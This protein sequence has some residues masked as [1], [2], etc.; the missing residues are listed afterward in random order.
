MR[1]CLLLEGSYPYITGGV[2]S[3]VQDMIVGLPEIEFALFTIS[4]AHDQTL[5]YKLPP[6][7]V[8]HVDLVI[9]DTGVSTARPRG[10]KKVMELMTAAHADFFARKKIDIVE[11]IERMPEGYFAHADVLAGSTGWNLLEKANHDHNPM[12]AFSDYFWSWKSSHNMLFA[13]LGTRPPAADIY[14]AI[15]TGYAGLAAVAAKIRRKKPFLLTEHGLYHKEREIE[16]R[17]ATFVRGYQR[18]MWI[19]IYN[20]LSRL[21]YQY[22]DVSTSLFEYNRRMQIELGAQEHKTE[23]IP[24]GIDVE[25][26]TVAREKRPG[27]HVGLVG[28]VVPIKDIKTFITMA[29]IVHSR[30]PEA[31]FYC[32][33]PTDEDPAYHEDCL[34]LVDS[35]RLGEVFE[36]TGRKNVLDYYAFLD[37]MLLTSVR[38]AQPLVILE[39]YAAGI[40]VVSTKVGNVAEMLDY[41][42]RFLAASKDSEK[43][44][45]SVHFIHS[46]PGEMRELAA[47]NRAKLIKLYNKHDL[48]DRY[49]RLY[50]RLAGEG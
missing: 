30:I 11:L 8:D 2:S 43:L 23:V 7:V 32:I 42:D 9:G 3:W 24:N 5:K 12:Y 40:P 35:F 29:R 22:A 46:H 25:R 39:A 27:F 31:R 20:S 18:D 37:V 17:K 19:G 47:R 49:R 13:V 33:G 21:A 34:R 44:A 15:S 16:L 1:V 38:E 28:R 6:N 50:R 4:P 10:R 26:F 45:W 14:H 41:D 36:F 48:F